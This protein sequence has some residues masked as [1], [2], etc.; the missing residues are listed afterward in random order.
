MSS[1]IKATQRLIHTGRD[2]LMLVCAAR[3]WP[4]PN[5]DLICTWLSGSDNEPASDN[6]VADPPMGGAPGARRRFSSS[7]ARLQP[8]WRQ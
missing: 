8:R 4:M 6:C 7:R 1:Q 3:L 5:G 2:N